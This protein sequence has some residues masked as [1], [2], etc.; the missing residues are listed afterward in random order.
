MTQKSQLR[1]LLR[2]RRAAIS[3]EERQS[4]AWATTHYPQI[5]QKLRRGKKIALYVPMGSEFPTWP[6]I[7]LALQRG[8]LVYLP[9][10]PKSGRQLSFVR[11]DHNA[12]WQLG[13][14]NIPI[15][16]NTEQCLARNLDT[17][18]VPLL[19]FDASLARLGQGG[20]FYDTTFAFRR[21]RKSWLKPRLIGLAFD[22]QRVDTLP[23]EPW[24]LRL[25][26]MATERAWLR[27]L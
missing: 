14:F 3:I 23:C 5:L 18:F 26:A 13:A 21:M 8:C 7:F 9:I 4:A 19:G 1:R 10:V 17:V 12:R 22:C 27:R 20:G 25:D 2:Q 6:L 16:S 15:P 24:D 11:L